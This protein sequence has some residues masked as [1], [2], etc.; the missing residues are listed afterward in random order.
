M[1]VE[2]TYRQLL[3]ELRRDFPSPRPDLDADQRLLQSLAETVRRALELRGPAARLTGTREAS[4]TTLGAAATGTSDVDHQRLAVESADSNQVLESLVA[5]LRGLPLEGHPRGQVNVNVQPSTPSLIGAFLPAIFNPNMSSDGRGAGCSHAEREVVAMVSSLIGYDARQSSGVFTFGG[6][7]TLLYGVKLGL[8]RACPHAMQRGLRDEVVVLASQRSHHT[9]LTSAGWLGIGSDQVRRV[10]VH[11]DNSVD[12][13]RLR[14]VARSDLRAG[15]KI[16]AIVATVGTTDAFGIDDLA[17]LARLR[18]ELVD[19]FHLDYRPHLH[20]DAVIGWAWSVFNDYD[21]AANPLGF[22]AEVLRGLDE[23]RPRIQAL[24][25]ADSL[26]IDFHKTGFVPYVSSLVL[27]RD[28]LDF[29]RIARQPELMPYL[30]HSGTYH[31]GLFTLET[32]RAA[33]GVLAAWANLHWL[34]RRGLQV[35]LGHALEMTARLRTRLRALPGVAVVND[36]NVGPVTLYRLYPDSVDG[37]ARF[38]RERRD[39]AVS[40]SIEGVNEFNRRVH[41]LSSAR[42]PDDSS[43]AFGLTSAAAQAADGSPLVALKSYLLSPWLEPSDL[44]AIV[45]QV[46]SCRALAG[47][48]ASGGRQPVDA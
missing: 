32:T 48:K 13:E 5:I 41:A 39:L 10:P 28:R 18:D 8:E 19:E 3:S 40:S 11:D 33:G 9:C 45:G 22:S 1:S 26:G 6:T 15:R 46:E 38:I 20:A 14:D 30:F 21:H 47:S 25:L 37:Q 27:V 36:A 44:D 34:G 29:Q 12:V 43:A 42:L 4:S 2:P 17:Q 24:A 7:G 35:L 23:A 16:A 31:P